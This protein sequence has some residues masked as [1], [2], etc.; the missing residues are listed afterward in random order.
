MRGVLMRLKRLFCYHKWIKAGIPY[1][2]ES[3]TTKRVDVKC[4]K[5]G[6]ISNVDIFDIPKRRWA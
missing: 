2:W 3:G 1:L 5:C 6:K 4:V